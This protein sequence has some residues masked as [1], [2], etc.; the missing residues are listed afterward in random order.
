MNGGA[1][2]VSKS[3]ELPMSI[4]R[5]VAR[6]RTALFDAL[7]RL[8]RRADYD[9]ITVEDILREADVGRSTFY[10]HFTSKGDL[11][12]KS[13]NRLK[14]ELLEASDAQHGWT[15]TRALFEHISR[16]ADLRAKLAG[17]GGAP[18]LAKAV[19]DLLATLLRSWLPPKMPDS[20][21]RDLI[22]GFMVA[23]L[24]STIRWW[25][26]KRPSLSPVEVDRL[27]MRLISEGLP[28]DLTTPLC[29]SD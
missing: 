2:S 9:R 7:V 28:A 15:P 29:G 17:G 10:S 24:E 14:E 26:E 8:I 4:D 23:A 25:L 1:A 5:R 22:V 16:H 18:V 3:R 20:V 21:P 12:Q 13:L 6:T 11:L 19:S 27:F